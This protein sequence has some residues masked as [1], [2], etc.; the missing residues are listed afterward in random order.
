MAGP[1]R[2]KVWIALA[3][4]G[5]LGVVTLGVAYKLRGRIKLAFYQQLYSGPQPDEIEVPDGLVAEL[6]TGEVEGARS[7]ALGPDGVLF[8]GSRGAGNVYA[9]VDRDGDYAV[10]E[11]H[12]VLQGRPQPNGVAFH[13]GAL[14]VAEPER[15]VRLPGILSR[16]ADPPAPE[17]VYETF[18]TG[19]EHQWKYLAFG[20]DG[21]LYVSV[22]APCN[23]CEP[24]DERY[25]TIIR[26][27]PDGSDLEV[28]ARGVRNS[29]GFTWHP[30]TGELWFTDNGR[31]WLGDDSPPDELDHAPT[32]GLDF[33]FPSCHGRDVADP[34]VEGPGCASFTAPARDLQPHGAHLG[35]RF[36][37][38]DA[39]GERYR[40]GLFIAQHGSWNRSES[41]GY[42]V[43]FVPMLDGRPGE[44]EPFATGWLR[45]PIAWGRPVD[46]Q[47]LADGSLLVSDDGSGAIYRIRRAGEQARSARASRGRSRPRALAS[48]AR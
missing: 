46:V 26:M 48:A 38:H 14:Y 11:V 24:G 4:A 10:D 13:D 33:G 29:V 35:L 5:V 27:R 7:M 22:G 20:P 8:V 36:Y 17:V 37:D 6:Y 30:T 16:L 12:V 2:R 1:R 28:Y 31:D 23:A 41:V 43:V 21:W 19:A 39:L 15:I 9:V 32:A 3:V 40:G 18:P 34:E 42:A 45:E 25:A 44:P 47:P